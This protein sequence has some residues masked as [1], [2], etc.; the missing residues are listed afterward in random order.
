MDRRTV[1]GGMLDAAIADPPSHA[2]S[3]DPLA[4][5]N[6]RLPTTPRAQSGL[7]SYTGLWGKDQIF[8]LLRR[9][10]FGP[11]P[12][13]AQ[14]FQTMSMS[15]AL[16][17]VL[18]PPAI[19]GGQPLNTDI[20]DLVAVGDTWVYANYKDAAS[21]FD[22]SGIRIVSLKSWWTGLML[23]QSASIMEKMVLFWHNH[24]VTE[25][26]VVNEPRFTWR[27]ADLLRRYALGNWKDLARAITIDGAMLR[28]LNGNSNTKTS[29]NE[30]YGRELQELFTIGKGPEVG[31]GDYTTYTEADVKAAAKVLTGWQEDATVLP[32]VGSQPSRFTATRHDTSNKQFSNRYGNRV[33]T[34]GTDGLAEV[35]A[36]LDMIFEQEETAKFLCRKLYRWFV[37]YV[38][39]ATTE[40]NVI[41]PMANILRQNNYEVMPVLQALFRS[42]HFYDPLNMGCMIKSPLE[43]VVGIPRIFTMSLPADV[44]TRYKIFYYMS[45]QAAAM[46]QDIADPPNVAGWAALYQSPQF[47]ELWINSDTLPRRASLSNSLMRSGYSTSGF[48]YAADPLAFTLNLPDP[49]NV[50]SLIDECARLI[51]AV[52]LTANQKAFLKQTLIPGLPDYEWTLEWDTYLADP[53]NTQK[54]NAVKTKLQSLFAFMLSMP[55]FQLQ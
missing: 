19:D 37:Y 47:Y 11:S 7:E 12:G 36:L 28:Y 41:V 30:N 44:S 16:D 29:P 45:T 43:F 49:R 5:T 53:G 4:F 21:T 42:A 52:P 31:P 2:I 3:D 18:S 54:M 9:T 39:D 14:A 22:P 35:N 50:D 32:Q 20:R 33:I 48:T 34:G 38:I 25:R 15:Q 46:Q 27:Y 26:D 23:T 55:E 13:D 10:T 1:L 40:A 8:H 6:T 17:L 51:F 24:F